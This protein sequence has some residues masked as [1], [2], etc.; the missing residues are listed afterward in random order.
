MA[1]LSNCI[2]GSI[3]LEWIFSLFIVW[4]K[5]LDAFCGL[6]TPEIGVF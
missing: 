5:G 1:L 2:G 6:V 3:V 4:I